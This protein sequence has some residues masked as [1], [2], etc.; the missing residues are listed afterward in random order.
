MKINFQKIGRIIAD[1][2]DSDYIDI[3]RDVGNDLQEIYSN[4]PCHLSFSSVDNPDPTTVDVKPIIQSIVVNLPNYVDIQNNDFLVMKRM[5]ND[6]ALLAVYSGRCGNPAASQGRQKVIVSMS[7][8]KA[9]EPTPIPPTQS[10]TITINFISGD[11]TIQEPT[12]IQVAAN[13]SYELVAPSIEGYKPEHCIIDEEQQVGSTA[14]IE[15]VGEV[16]HVITFSYSVLELP[17][18]LRILVKGLYTRDDGSLANGYH[19]YKK[20]EIEN[21]QENNGGYIITCPDDI[22]IHEETGKPISIESGEKIILMPGN[23]FVKITEIIDKS[24]SSITFNAVNF[25]P[26]EEEKQAY[27]TRWYD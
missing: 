1:Y 27:I 21:I 8:T 7:A 9:E 24:D 10:I 22:L 11:V 14:Y 23:I 6:N 15:D 25:I 13:S 3:K 26:D 16:N 20:I 5:S 17:S 18:Y 4:V 12:I 2:F 19:F